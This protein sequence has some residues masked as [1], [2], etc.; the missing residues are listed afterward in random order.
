M[1][2]GAERLDII[3]RQDNPSGATCVRTGK[4][5]IRPAD[6]KAMGMLGMY[7]VIDAATVK[8]LARRKR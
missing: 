3:E 4:A 5:P 8:R 6:R 1:R 7:E 2:T